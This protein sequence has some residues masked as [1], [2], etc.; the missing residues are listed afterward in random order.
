MESQTGNLSV[1]ENVFTLIPYNVYIKFLALNFGF[2]DPRI[3][4]QGTKY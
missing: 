4:I 3:R 2:L 1:G